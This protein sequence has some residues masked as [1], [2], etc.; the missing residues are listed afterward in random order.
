MSINRKDN[1]NNI[2]KRQEELLASLKDEAKAIDGDDIIKQNESLASEIKNIKEKNSALS[3]E[4]EQLKNE[5]SSTKSA[6]F[7]KLAN[8]K[9]ITFK[10]V[11]KDIENSYYIGEEKTANRLEEYR[12]S[13]E[14]S[15]DETI[16]A[17]NSYADSEY[18]EILSKFIELK[19]EFEQKRV[20]VESYS[21]NQFSNL[22]Q[23]NNK[24]G[25]KL[26]DEPLSDTEK[27]TSLK[28]KNIESFIGLNVL[29]KAGILLF[30]IGI[31][32]LGR[33]A[34]IHMSDLFKCLLIYALGAILVTIGEL[35]Y[36]KE[37]NVFSTVLI[38]GGVAVLYAATASG[39][40]AFDVFSARLTFLICIFVTAMAIFLSAQT[41][42]QII[43]IFASIGGYLPVVVLY[44]IGFGKAASDSMFL[45]VSSAYFCLL[46]IVVFIMTYNKKWHAAQFISFA[47]HIT[48]VGG[49]GACS[50]ALKDLGGYGY[51]LPLSAAFSIVS[52][53]IYLAMASGKIISGKTLEIEDTV[54]FGL[55]TVTGAV[56][57]GVTLYHCFER[58]VA[59]RVVGAVFLIFAVFYLFLFSK[60]NKSGKKDNVSVGATVISS[61]SA[62]V[63]SMLIVPY[64]F[65]LA[66]APIAWAIEGAFIAI[67]GIEKKLQLPEAAGFFCIL[68]SFSFGFYYTYLGKYSTVLSIAT[69]TIILITAWSYALFGLIT[70]ENNSPYKIIETV[71][72]VFTFGYLEFIYYA[73]IKSPN[74]KYYSAF[75]NVAIGIIFALALATAL[76]LGIFKNKVSLLLSDTV[77]I[78]LMPITFIR[79]N[80]IERYNDITDFYHIQ[81]NCEPYKIFNIILLAAVNIFVGVFFAKC[82]AGAINRHGASVWIFTLM[83]SICVLA[84]T[85]ST[86]MAQFGVEFSNAIISTIYI[87]VSIVL[88]VIGFKKNYT[89]VRSSGLAIILCTFAKLCFVDTRNLESSWKILSY[90][91]FGAILIVI[92]FVYQKFSKKLENSAV[93]IT[94]DKSEN[95]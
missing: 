56:S 91:A 54:L 25:D 79:L 43:C 93:N 88:L 73:I 4:N 2:I 72:A 20:K 27:K 19:K 7:T 57:I 76:R 46:A 22:S 45:P 80:I 41:K 70:A 32:L 86:L 84:L 23:T 63:F 37:K 61:L 5:L 40:F 6:L 74:I 85:T 8:E 49:V 53:I 39:Y 60:I 87:I 42:N 3:K 29:G 10:R 65:G 62:L 55:N 69:F 48:A 12:K 17:I 18:G 38:S 26:R 66:Y 9:L 21:K 15:L 51:A 24:I 67:L 83:T 59:N 36:K 34:Y 13:C 52:F 68:L 11:Q 82:I 58:A 78:I 71:M 95:E 1:L 50:W 89:I 47:L 30:I 81:A 64:M 44:L 90:F 75:T 14:K 16:N 35:F 31:I 92:S 28:Q 77:G 33:Y 94:A